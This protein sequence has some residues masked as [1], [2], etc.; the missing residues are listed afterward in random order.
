VDEGSTF[1]RNEGEILDYMALYPRKKDY[2]QSH[3]ENI[4]SNEEIIPADVDLI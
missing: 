2:S 1:L 4:K 3:C